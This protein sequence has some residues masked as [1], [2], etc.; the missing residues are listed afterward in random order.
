M[1]QEAP[2]LIDNHG[3]RVNYLRLAV[4]D[5]CNLRCFYCMPAEGITYLPKPHLLSFEEMLRLC[6][7][8]AEMGIEKV[9]I[10]GGEPFLRRDLMQFLRALHKIEGI[11]Q[12]HIT[13][14]GVLTLPHVAELKALG[15]ASINLSLD[16]TDPKRFHAITRRDEFK[17]VWQTLEALLHHEIPT[18]IN[19]VVMAGI[20]ENDIIPLVNLAKAMPL[21]VRFIEEMP[22]NGDG[23]RKTDFWD[24]KR[25]LDEI[26]GVYPSLQK[27]G[28][29]AFSTS[30]NYKIDGFTGNVG[31]IA[32]FSR[33]F[34]GTCNRLR[35]T[36]TGEV[37]TCLYADSAW[38]IRDAMRS[39]QDDE[40]LKATLMNLHQHR[41]AD[42][43]EAESMR[44][45]SVSESMTTIGG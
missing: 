40:A 23:I 27:I 16:T 43:F 31:V 2:I 41:H 35:V 18:K 38:N 5:R 3:R 7:I 11:K 33:T 13:T 1:I 19:A 8:G 39:G 9:R 45:E 17:Q 12:V 26:K 29:E 36:P 20:N 25:I 4:T 28:D 10:T 37:K 24:F 15:I 21:S 22:F 14:N 34:C 32:A 30:Y 42:G 44:T 6:R